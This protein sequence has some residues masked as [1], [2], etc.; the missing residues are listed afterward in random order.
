MY[1]STYTYVYIYIYIYICSMSHYITLYHI[2]GRQALGGGQTGSPLIRAA[3][4]VMHFDRSGKKAR[5]GTFGKIKVGQREYP[6][7]PSV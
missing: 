6:K 5:P 1:I 3:A 7:G 4:E 2:S